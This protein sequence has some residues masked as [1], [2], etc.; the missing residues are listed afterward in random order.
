MK[1]KKVTIK[2]SKI[3]T[4]EI[5]FFFI[6]LHFV[7][8]LPGLCD[9]YSRRLGEVKGTT[10]D[11]Y[12]QVSVFI[13]CKPDQVNNPWHLIFLMDCLKLPIPLLMLDISLKYLFF[14]HILT[15]KEIPVI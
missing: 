3:S 9:F 5:F 4:I 7:A 2:I 14:Y 13:C 11:P 1:T 12:P 15:Q 10:V 6:L 8:K